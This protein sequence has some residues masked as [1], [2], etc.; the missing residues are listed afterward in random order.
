MINEQDQERPRDDAEVPSKSEDLGRAI[1]AELSDVLNALK[2][3]QNGT[4]LGFAQTLRVSWLGL[5]PFLLHLQHPDAV[6]W[7]PMTSTV[8]VMPGRTAE[9]ASG[10]LPP[11]RVSDVAEARRVARWDRLEQSRHLPDDFVPNDWE[12]GV[13]R[14]RQGLQ[15]LVLPSYAYVSLERVRSDGTTARVSRP[16]LG[17]YADRH[18]LRP[19]V[20]V[21]GAS[22]VTL[23]AAAVLA[24]A[25]LLLVD[26]Q[27][28]RGRK[29]QAAIHA[30][31]KARDPGQ[32]TLVIA[33]NPA[34]VL[35]L[36]LDAQV[37][38]NATFTTIGPKARLAR[39]TVRMTGIDRLS[40]DAQFT[41][42]LE[43]AADLGD[44]GRHVA[45]LA[46]YAWWAIR[47]STALE[48]GRRELERF[49]RALQRMSDE[50]AFAASL[51]TACHNLLRD[52]FL[53]VELRRQRLDSTVDAV[54]NAQGT[55]DVLVVSR[56]A[57]NAAALTNAVARALDVTEADLTGLGVSVAASNAVPAGVTPETVVLV[58]YGGIRTITATL[59]TPAETAVAVFDPVETRIAW[60]NA[61]TMADYFDQAGLPEASHPLR[62]F[63]DGLSPHVVGFAE[64][65]ELGSV[66]LSSR[67][68]E[69][70]E[71][72]PSG[73]RSS[74]DGALVYFVDGTWLEVPLGTRFE[75]LGRNGRGSQVVTV[76]DIAPG[77]EIVML[78]PEARLLFSEKRMALLDEGPLKA[79][80]QARREWILIVQ[81]V[82]KAKG[83]SPGII[84]RELRQRGHHITD[85]AVRVWVSD[86]PDRARAPQK[87]SLFKA[88]AE[89]LNIGFSDEMLAFYFE[90]IRTWRVSHRRAGRQVAQAIRLAY[91]GRLGSFSLARIERDWG[92]GIRSLVAVAHV[93]VVD[94]VIL[95][96]EEDNNAHNRIN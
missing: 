40:S 42:S 25:D 50:D 95:P 58:G 63:A 29:A 3:A 13:N 92:I 7:L 61:T 47:Q 38:A 84:A 80:D 70:L 8:T 1:N 46:Q 16:T 23:D 35:S 24:G 39:V 21:S 67:F 76:S 44:A 49:E 6:S 14:H 34:D 83:F 12:S 30:V 10:L 27:G 28:I 71:R 51:F 4:V 59:Q 73:T 53:D 37:M 22:D 62:R 57:A 31:L 20:L 81:T 90:N 55:G 96:R 5:L 94:E 78:D 66:D 72:A 52:A 75:R 56:S 17:R 68:P 9:L 48:A 74:S 82:A 45:Q 11:F 89:V 69:T 19:R 41:A 18:A 26:L 86:D 79:Q 2:M 15:H 65:Q 33:S 91:S 36:G 54:L 88:L 87:L 32:P 64:L 77:D 60:Y 85:P 43:G 93:G